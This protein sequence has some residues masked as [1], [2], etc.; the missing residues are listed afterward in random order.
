MENQDNLFLKQQFLMAMPSMEDPNF[1]KTVTCICEHTVH[2]AVGIVINRLH[3][4]IKCKDIFKELDIEYNENIASLP[5]HVGGPVNVGEIF[6]L[7]GKPLHWE[8]SIMVS[9]SLAISNTKDVLTAIA[10]GVGPQLFLLALGCAGWGPGQLESE[11]KANVWL[12]NPMTEQIIFQTP[13]ESKWQ[14]AV[15]KVGIDPFFI[16]NTAGH[17]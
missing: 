10:T 12:T 9:S 13:V 16:T 11:I 15:K 3:P 17:A 1:S 4:D 14:E 7:H 5:V 8:G 2:G 6:I